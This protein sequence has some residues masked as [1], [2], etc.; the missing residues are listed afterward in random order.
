MRFI[1]KIAIQLFF[2]MLVLATPFNI[3]ARRWLHGRRGN[4]KK[5]RKGL[6]TE[7]PVYWFHCASLG[8][9]EQGRSVMEE[10]RARIPESF[11]L[12][13]FF[14]PSGYG[15]RKNY[16]GAD[17]VAYLPL[18]TRLNA[19]RFLNLVK[20]KA[21]FFIKY[22]YW[23]Y[24]L[25]TCFRKRIPVYLVSGK[26]R[27]DQAFFKWYGAW[28]RK[29]L[30]FF[31][32]FFVQDE[33]SAKLLHSVG[34]TNVM[35]AGD[36]RFDRVYQIAG[37]SRE[38]PEIKEFKGHSQVVVAGSTWEEDEEL[39]I[40]NIN[41]VGSKVK[42]ILAPHEINSR[43][44]YRLISQI[45]PL[46]VRFTEE[47]KRLYPKARVL[48]IDTIGHLSSVYKYGD[49]A[50]IGGGFGRGIHNTLEAA[51]YGLPVIFG[52]NYRKFNEAI[53]L[54]AAG[55]AFPVSNQSEFNHAVE[56]L[57]GNKLLL[58]ESSLKA[59]QYV[60]SRIGATRII[61]DKTLGN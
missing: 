3:K 51:T 30:N 16:S 41:Q 34:K 53:E 6:L 25:R 36:T 57:L 27:E 59:R 15:L 42:F 8:E 60:E 11:I 46:V 40:S 37:R 19:W 35:V 22:D 14:S 12:L 47:D 45:E 49:I 13:T 5:L 31:T 32:Y 29:F 17:L 54:L 58:G 9:F 39:I 50:Y 26:F 38:Y 44:I 48:L 43:K 55:A 24:F 56:N 4:W 7:K 23:Y 33:T 61:L 20:P 21:A 28:Y 10:L 18:D 2:A 1:Y 52:P